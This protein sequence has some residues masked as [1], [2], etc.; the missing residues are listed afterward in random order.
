MKWFSFT[1][2]LATGEILAEWSQ[3]LSFIAKKQLF[4]KRQHILDKLK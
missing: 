1:Q 4:K 2:I 3:E